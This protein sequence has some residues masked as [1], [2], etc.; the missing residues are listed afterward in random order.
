VPH[1]EARKTVLSG[2]S[3]NELLR[4]I[5]NVSKHEIPSIAASSGADFWNGLWLDVRLAVR[6]LR[7]NPGFATVAILTLAIG[8]GANTAIFSLV[9]RVL[10]RPLYPD[11]QRLVVLQ[12]IPLAHKKQKMNMN[13]AMSYPIYQAWKDNKD[14]FESVGA[15]T[16]QG[17][18]LTGMGDPERLMAAFV[19]SDFLPMLG[20]QPIVGRAFTPQ[21]EPYSSPA[22]VLLSQSFWRSHFNSDRNVIGRK[23]TLNDKPVTVIGVIPNLSSFRSGGTMPYDIVLPLREE[24][25]FAVV[26]FNHLFVL[27]KIRSDLSPASAMDAIEVRSKAINAKFGRNTQ[28]IQV[29][30]LETFLTVNA[31]PVVLI[32]FGAVAVVLLIACANTANLLLARGAAREKE[33]AIRFALGARRGR[34]LRQLLTETLLIS[35]VAATLGMAGMWATQSLLTNLLADR[36]PPD[37]SAQIDLSALVFTFALALLV[38]VIFSI[39]PGLLGGS[40]GLRGKL[41]QG[42]RL[43]MAPASHRM[44]NALIVAEI[45]FSLVL[46][47]GTGLLLRS[48][49]RL[50][51]TDKGFEAD[52]VLTL[53]IWPSPTRYSDPR[54][55]IS[56]MDTILQRTEA[57][58]GVK[59]A[60]WATCL[61]VSGTCISGDF[62]IK[63]SDPQKMIMGSKQLVAG[64]YFQAMH[65]RLSSG[66]LFNPHDTTDSAPVAIIDQ[67]FAKQYFGSESPIGKHINFS[68]GKDGWAEVVGVVGEVKESPDAPANPTAYVPLSQKPELVGQLA[69]S[70]AVRTSYDPA[71]A[72][73]SIRQVIHQI[74]STQIIEAVHT[75]DEVVDS[76]VSSRRSPLWL[77]SGFGGIALFLSA[78]GVYGVLSFHVLQRRE[79]IGTRMAL[80]AQRR[81]ILSLVLGHA[82]KL[83]ALGIVAGA[84]ISLLAARALQS[85]L[86]GIRPTDA[87]T[88]LAVCAVLATVALLA[89]GV[90]LFRATRVDPQVVLRNE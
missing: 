46:L 63:G 81:D 87:G 28:A 64:N 83:I 12:D 72:A 54:R 78:I 74:D 89:C 57:L 15:L 55:Y 58:P 85:L 29:V 66:R 34:L 82:A 48:F 18:S 45:A 37:V 5:R 33:I 62:D 40:K 43:S 7:K 90:P 16:S 56:Y 17:P 73:A 59:T 20:V 39:L 41:N 32:L 8:F 25:Q 14:I 9:E 60:G 70:L 44:R 22:V 76:S 75:M 2:L 61:P 47:V 11:I 21:D 31:R 36:L 26:G 86:Y 80:G 69:F 77:F 53:R 19:S 51:Q 84:V 3:S 24:P 71:E 42:G 6:M 52:H 68:W 10:L 23:L 4:E 88:L 1:D 35:L 65:V 13:F 49:V 50:M 30:P 79:E 38:A 27:G 67:A